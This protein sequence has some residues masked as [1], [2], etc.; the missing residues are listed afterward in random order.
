MSPKPFR[1]IFALSATNRE[2]ELG[3]AVDYALSLAREMDAHASF[4]LIGQKFE[5]PYSMAPGFTATL[6]GPANADEKDRLA[7]SESAL[8]ERLRISDTRHDLVAEQ[9]T[10]D[11]A[12]ALLAHD[13]RIHDLS[14]MDAPDTFL[15]WGRAIAEELLFD[16]GRP[17]IIVPTG[18]MAF[19]AK[20]IL[21]AWDGTAKAAR[22]L[23]D[24]M[25]LLVA[26]D[27]VELVS[28]SGEKDLAKLPA[29]AEVATHLSRHGI[30]AEVV[31]LDAVG[32][33]P[34]A[35]LRERATLADIDLIVM[36]AYAHSRWRQMVFGG[37][38]DSML[39]EARVPLF[40][41]A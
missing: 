1:N 36:G 20:R 30:R 37:V 11:D 26:A 33:S 3:S 18:S 28:V 27:H 5:S 39:S 8:A 32:K 24:A 35:V 10:F 29:G 14:I 13:A 41:S 25:P 16:S 40:L 6:T 9:S 23:N 21:V 34:G 4:R 19:K 38:T 22:A 7:K 2:G 31:G 15:A 17:V 12:M